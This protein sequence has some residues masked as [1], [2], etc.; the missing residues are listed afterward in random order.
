MQFLSKPSLDI[1]DEPDVFILALVLLA[2]AASGELFSIPVGFRT[3]LASIPWIVRWVPGFSVNGQHRLAAILH[4][5]LY[6]IQ[7]RDRAAADALF[8]EA[9]EACGVGMALRG[10]L[11][12]GVRTGGWWAWWQRGRAMRADRAAYLVDNGLPADAVKG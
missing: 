12:A 11:Y 5:Y 1:A 10:T 4:D 6:T 7:D 2:R 3:D 8:L 9:M